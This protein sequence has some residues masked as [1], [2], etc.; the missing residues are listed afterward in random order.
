[1]KK[2]EVYL[3]LV[4]E[5]HEDLKPATLVSWVDPDLLENAVIMGLFPSGI[6]D[7]SEVTHEFLMTYLK[8]TQD[9][10]ALLYAEDLLT[11]LKTKV[12]CNVNEPD[13]N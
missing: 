6:K 13:P 8:S 10:N 3:C 9:T 7:V 2:R 4:N 5:V 1:L 11:Q 12:V